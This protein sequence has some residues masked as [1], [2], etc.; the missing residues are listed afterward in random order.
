MGH[1]AAE[2]RLGIA[3][4]LLAEL[5]RWHG[6]ADWTGPVAI[7]PSAILA[8]ALAYFPKVEASVVSKCGGHMDSYSAENE[9]KL[10]ETFCQVPQCM[11]R[12]NSH[13]LRVLLL[14]RLLR[15]YR[16]NRFPPLAWV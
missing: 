5:G 12:V 6:P 15:K 13:G 7:S 3:P 8:V 2:W 1:V 14:L 9:C 10:L 11:V 16:V 4:R